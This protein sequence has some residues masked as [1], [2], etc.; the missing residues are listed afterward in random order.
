MTKTGTWPVRI[1]IL[2]LFWSLKHSDLW[3]VSSFWFRIS[4]F[5]TS[6]KFKPQKPAWFW[7]VRVMRDFK[8]KRA[9]QERARK[10]LSWTW[11]IDPSLELPLRCDLDFTNPQIQRPALQ[12]CCLCN[13]PFAWEFQREAWLASSPCPFGG[14]F[15][16]KS[17]DSLSL[18]VIQ[19][20]CY[21]CMYG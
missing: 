1:W 9:L 10:P 19:P 16:L 17:S 7:L 3:F 15:Q 12:R 2:I 21:Y 6:R 8:Q 20:I 11:E 5:Q 4:N 14:L 13:D 18:H